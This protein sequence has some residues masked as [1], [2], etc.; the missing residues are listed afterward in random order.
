MYQDVLVYVSVCMYVSVCVCDRQ[1]RVCVRLQVHVSRY[2][3]RCEEERV[4]G[5]MMKSVLHKLCGHKFGHRNL[6]E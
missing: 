1:G 5:G 3:S 4:G 6:S 2:V